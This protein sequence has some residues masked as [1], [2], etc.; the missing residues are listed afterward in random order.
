MSN[1]NAPA[2]FQVTRHVTGGEQNRF[3]RYH[4][5]SAL[6][7]N[8]YRGDM[9]IPVNTSKNITTPAGVTNRPIGVFDG[10]FYI[11]TNGE[12]QFRPRW[13][14]GTTIKTG[15]V[16]DANV[17][18]DPKSLFEIQANGAFALADIGALADPILGTGNNLTGQSGHQLDS[19]TIGSGTVLKI[20]TTLAR[21]RK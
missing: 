7:A 17:Y 20:I 14:T 16:V 15:T 18:D 10:C 2:G 21:T 11:D 12:V 8:L 6:A 13:I 3:N 1:R 5:A 4:I 19:S 9:V